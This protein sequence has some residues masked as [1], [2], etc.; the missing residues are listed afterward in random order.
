M[1]WIDAFTRALAW[2]CTV[3]DFH[4]LTS[5]GQFRR[6]RRLA[7]LALDEHRLQVAQLLPLVHGENTTFRAIL[8]TGDHVVVRIHRTDYQTPA[9]IH[10]ELSW[11]AAIRR[12]V[13]IPTP[14][15]RTSPKGD[16]VLELTTPGVPE[17]RCVVIFDWLNGRFRTRAVRPIEIRRI[18][19]AMARLHRHSSRWTPPPGFTRHRWDIATMLP[20]DELWQAILE[21]V[22][23]SV[24]DA[25]SGFRERTFTAVDT[26]G[27]D[28]QRFGLVHADLHFWNV[29]HHRDGLRILDFD[30]CGWSY[31]VS[32]VATALMGIRDKPEHVRAFLEGYRSERPFT[33]EEEAMLSVF[34]QLRELFELRWVAERKDNP[35]IHAYFDRSVQRCMEWL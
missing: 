9:S 32:D 10:S 31:Y 28:A 14:R 6:M 24:A 35:S 2:R 30:D 1:R 34:Y 8:E 25:L 20:D 16:R 7:A 3:K 29:L 17:T 26:W 13:G 21:K 22:K 33:S 11:T 19:L 18:G 23:G 5:A 4:Q 15:P 12:E 27:T